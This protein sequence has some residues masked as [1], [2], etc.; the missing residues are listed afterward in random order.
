MFCVFVSFLAVYYVI[1][2]RSSSNS[3]ARCRNGMNMQ[4]LQI[5]S[6]LAVV[7]F[8]LFAVTCQLCEMCKSLPSMNNL[9]S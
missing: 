8:L 3:I 2:S 6:P 4:F 1:N 9:A 7:N 5:A